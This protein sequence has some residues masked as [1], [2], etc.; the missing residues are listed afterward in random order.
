MVLYFNSFFDII[1][2][3]LKTYTQ[4]LSI[5]D[6]YVKK[7]F[8]KEC[9]ANQNYLQVP[10]NIIPEEYL[11]LR[12]LGVQFRAFKFNLKSDKCRWYDVT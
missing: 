8:R 12:N 9:F 4:F 11:E 5:T 6:D 2:K 7:L 3:R 10:C 1:Q